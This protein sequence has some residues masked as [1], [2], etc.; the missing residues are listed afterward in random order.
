MGRSGSL[1]IA[2]DAV[3]AMCRRLGPDDRISIVASSEPA[4]VLVSDAR[5][6][7]LPQIESALASLQAGRASNFAAALDLAS[8]VARRSSPTDS[9]VFVIVTNGRTEPS[10]I[11]Q[12]QLAKVLADT[13]AA[14]VKLDIVAV[15]TDADSQGHL[16]EL[17][18]SSKGRVIST[19]SAPDVRFALLES[20]T[21][22]SQVVARKTSLKL[23]FNP[24]AVDRYRL[25]GH[26]AET[27]TAPAYA[28]LEVDLRSG[29][30]ATALVELWLKPTGGDDVAT[31]ELTWQDAT[32]GGGKLQQRISRLQFAKSFA[33][34]PA[35]L[36][37]AYAVAQTAETLRGSYYVPAGKSLRQVL[38]LAGS[39]SD[40]AQSEPSL[41]DLLVLARRTLHIQGRTGAGRPAAA[42]P[43]DSSP[44]ES[45]A[46]T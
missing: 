24:Q 43:V 11:A 41:R 28:P 36:Q 46:G 42:G 2:K 26:E 12:Q 4:Q 14:G 3:S 17:A 40:A 37:T 33:E 27:V 30:A 15:G 19:R 44:A 29:E 8:S 5:A 6:D 20:L 16:A 22:Q 34:T 18:E 45:P 38:E 10:D 13:T 32:G 39:L 21:G 1:D 31:A 7:E 23:V 9:R 25:V 35:S